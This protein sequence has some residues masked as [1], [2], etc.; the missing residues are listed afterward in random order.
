MKQLKRLSLFALSIFVLL[1]FSVLSAASSSGTCLVYYNSSL[2][3]SGGTTQSIN[4]RLSGFGYSSYRY[5][6]H[7]KAIL[8]SALNGSNKIVF[9]HTHGASSGGALVCSDGQLSFSSVTGSANSMDYLSACYSAYPASSGSSCKG[10]MSALGVPRVVGF[11]NTISASTEYNGI[12]YFNDNVFWYLTTT[13]KT[14]AQSII[15]A[16]AD[17]L[18][19]YG[20][21][22]GSDQTE[23]AGGNLKLP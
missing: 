6:N 7:T 13:N 9:T 20:G 2:V 18:Y 1:F 23:Y 22:Y 21:Y 17:T 8:K 14:I 16:R 15:Q 3:P 12:H 4:N 19:T 11:R 10:R 5:A